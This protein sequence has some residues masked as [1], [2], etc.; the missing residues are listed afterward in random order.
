[1]VPVFWPSWPLV[2]DMGDL[3][4]S[5]TVTGGA[6]SRYL[7]VGMEEAGFVGGDNQWGVEF[8]HYAIDMSLS[9]MRRYH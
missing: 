9:R 5:I 8:G 6:P 7:T 4:P 3:C 2:R 1:M